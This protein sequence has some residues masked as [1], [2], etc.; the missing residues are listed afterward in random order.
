MVHTVKDVLYSSEDPY[1]A[2]LT[3]RD[4]PGVAGVSPAMLLIGRRLQMR[5]PALPLR[6]A[7]VEP[8]HERFQAQ[9]SKNEV[10]QARDFIRCHSTSSLGPLKPGDSV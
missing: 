7:S 8:S 2:L 6:L 9:D 5:L 3:Y 10:R 4:T 1:L